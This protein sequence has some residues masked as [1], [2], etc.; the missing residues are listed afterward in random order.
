MLYSVP[1]WSW[2]PRLETQIEQVSVQRATSTDGIGRRLPVWAVHA[3]T[4]ASIGAADIPDMDLKF[5]ACQTW[6][7]HASQTP[8]VVSCETLAALQGCR[9]ANNVRLLTPAGKIIKQEAGELTAW[10]YWYG[11]LGAVSREAVKTSA[12]WNSDGSCGP[13]HASSFMSR[14]GFGETDTAG[15]LRDSGGQ[16][17]LL[18]G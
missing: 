16:R 17:G 6:G 4:Q 13:S 12:G 3:R 8:D 5:S 11:L 10:R 2:L 7:V 1:P 9:I 15:W 18:R 14:W